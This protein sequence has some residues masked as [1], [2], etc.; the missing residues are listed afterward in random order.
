[1]DFLRAVVRVQRPAV[2]SCERLSGVLTHDLRPGSRLS[3][4][5]G[6]TIPDVE[7]EA[8]GLAHRLNTDEVVGDEL[9]IALADEGQCE[10]R[11]VGD[12][13]GRGLIFEDHTTTVGV[14]CVELVLE[15]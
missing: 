9:G 6:V 5:E 15:D 8:G 4:G 11:E 13:G 14:P 1:M 3:L 10:P 12:V 7:D 2:L